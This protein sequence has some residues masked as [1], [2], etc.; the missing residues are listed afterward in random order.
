[1]LA[2]QLLSKE[3]QHLSTRNSLIKHGTVLSCVVSIGTISNAWVFQALIVYF[4]SKYRVTIHTSWLIQVFF[5]FRLEQAFLITGNKCT[6]KITRV[7]RKWLI[8]I[9]SDWICIVHSWRRKFGRGF[10]L[11]KKA[12]FSS[13]QCWNQQR[14]KPGAWTQN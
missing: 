14:N 2:R 12:F 7:E 8:N 10:K 9:I 11:F 4:R 13:W 3:V 5:C 6:P 1:M